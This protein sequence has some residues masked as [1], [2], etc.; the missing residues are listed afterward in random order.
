MT[1][2]HA[3]LLSQNSHLGSIAFFPATVTL[4]MKNFIINAYRIHDAVRE[5]QVLKA[6]MRINPL[7]VHTEYNLKEQD[8]VPYDK[9]YEQYDLIALTHCIEQGAAPEKQI[10]CFAYAISGGFA[11][12]MTVNTPLL[13][14]LNV[15]SPSPFANK[16]TN[17]PIGCC[18][19][20]LIA[21]PIGHLCTIC[22]RANRKIGLGCSLTT[23]IV[24]QPKRKFLSKEK[25]QTKSFVLKCGTG[26]NVISLEREV[27][28]FNPGMISILFHTTDKRLIMGKYP[29]SMKLNELAK[30]LVCLLSHLQRKLCGICGPT[31][32]WEIQG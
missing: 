3:T 28:Y 24:T 20:C 6:E 25:E 5:G 21:I 8:F 26:N 19:R 15:L 23:K 32:H 17:I 11:T 14:K 29:T 18:N 7:F 4:T 9:D 1:Q 2:L 22:E 10:D 27:L 12:I 31:Q 13:M 16:Q 30:N